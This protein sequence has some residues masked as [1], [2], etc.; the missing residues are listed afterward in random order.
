M[1]G[2]WLV[3]SERIL[4]MNN[5]IKTKIKSLEAEE[6]RMALVLHALAYLYGKVSSRANPSRHRF[7]KRK[8]GSA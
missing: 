3:D 5:E 6:L 2:Q 8:D 4:T 1:V 7:D